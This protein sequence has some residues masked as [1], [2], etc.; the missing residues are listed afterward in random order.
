MKKVLM[1]C[2]LLVS[3]LLQQAMA[4]VKA[5][6]GKVT[7]ATTNQPLPGVTVLVKGTTAGTATGADGSYSINVPANGNTLVFRFIGYL[8]T[9]RAIGNASTVNVALPLDTKQ[10]SEVV[11]TALGIER[12]KKEIGYA[13]A[14]V[15]QEVVTRANP[16]NIA[17][18]L[19]GKVAGLNI[20][21]TNNGVFENV[22]INLRGI[23]SITGNNNP[24]LVLDGVP[25][26]INYLSSINPNDIEN[27]S[28]LKGSSAAAIYGPDARNGVI[29]V[30][31]KKGS[32][33]EKPTVTVGH[34]TQLQQISFFPKFQTQFGSGGYGE[35]IPYENWSWGPAF[36]GSEV[37]IG[38]VLPDGSVQKVKYSPTNDRKEFFKT[39]ITTQNDISFG[40]KDFYISFQ[41]AMIKGIVPDDENRRTGLRLNTGREYGKFKVG[42]NTNYIQ[43]NYNVFDDLAMEDYHIANNVGL[44]GGLMNLIF[45]TPAHIPINNYK[46]FKNDP[47]AEYNG[48]FN[49]YGLNPYFAIDNWR[50]EGKR[51]DLLTNLD[52]NFK[53]TD[54]LNL[55][56]RAGLTNQNITERRTSKG[57][58][59]TPYGIDRGFSSIPGAVQERAYK[60]SRLSSEAFASLNKEISESFKVTGIVG[61]YVRQ[62]DTRDT[63]V[64]AGSLVVP[65]LFN[66]ENLTGQLTGSSPGT[67]SRLFS[68]YASAGLSYKG[69]ANVEITG[70][71]DWTSVLAIG[72]HS[73]FYPGVNASLVLSDAISGLANSNVLSYLKLRGS[74]SKTGNAEISPYLLAATFSQANGFPYGGLPGYTAGNTTYDKNLE[75]EFIESKE[76]GFESGF[77]GGKI[78]L[79]ATYYQQNND[80]QIIPISVSSATGYTQNNINAASFINQGVEMDLRLTPLVNLGGVK[81]DFRANATYSDSE[82]KSI[83]SGLDELFIGGFAAAGNF[84]IVGQP[85]FVI[86]ATD[87]LRDP[88]GRVIVDAVTG[89]PSA[90]PNLKT[91]GRTLP[92]WIVGLNPSASWKG[93]NLSALAEYKGGHYAYNDIG[94]AMAWTGVSAASA[95]N[96]REKFVFP[97]SS[98]L[99]PDG[100]Y[101]E[102]TNVTVSNVNDF[103]TGVFRSVR[104][105]FI[106]SASHW[107][108][109]EVALSYELPTSFLSRQNVVKGATV[110]LTGRNLVLWLPESNEFQDPDFNFSQGNAAGITTSQINPPTRTFGA[111]VTLRF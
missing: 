53:A 38:H 102:N 66:I 93:F 35:Y 9:E 68:T 16:V 94:S 76:F 72:N 101:V 18:G 75:P 110:A 20:T 79:E 26:N 50:K 73:F 78:N 96:N 104:S 19:Q 100:T 108:L 52:L 63:R 36:D 64:G 89:Y 40:A 29:I 22:K 95:R 105:N 103:Y 2:F 86:K 84:A 12:Q 51:E 87:Y 33:D 27:V 5:I 3:A 55:T 62:T 106:T 59:P 13:T 80:N 99:G 42:L 81:L 69:W 48:F 7:D 24:L 30:T 32:I 17:N 74:W 37:E 28:V 21:S 60:Y 83:Y 6:T 82:I 10:L 98:I 97:N 57:E 41:D 107:R 43:Q 4:Q 39:G 109:R 8:S 47:F 54:W 71:N 49:D 44:N 14:T 1:L 70:R 11:V 34:S 15:S 91:F 25:A 67:R 85:A 58:I 92:K 88:Q 46:D 111:N 56:Y 45:N 31:T 90:D 61:T 77:M 23:R 65:E